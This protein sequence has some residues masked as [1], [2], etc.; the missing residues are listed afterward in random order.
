[1]HTAIDA[2][3]LAAAKMNA[4]IEALTMDERLEVGADAFGDDDPMLGVDFDGDVD[5]Y[6]DEIGVTVREA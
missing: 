4:T 6:L 1:M 5:E 2:A 3:S